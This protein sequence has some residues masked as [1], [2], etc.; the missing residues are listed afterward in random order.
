[1]T[2]AQPAELAKEDKAYKMQLYATHKP[3]HRT[4]KAVGIINELKD[5]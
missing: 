3:Y 5:N 2:K 1:M 4:P